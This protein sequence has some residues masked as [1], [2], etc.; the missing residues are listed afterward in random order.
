MNK[1]LEEQLGFLHDYARKQVSGGFLG[2]AVDEYY[3]NVLQS[4]TPPTAEELIKA[5]NNEFEYEYELGNFHETEDENQ[6]IE[7]RNIKTKYPIVIYDLIDKEIIFRGAV[8]TSTKL[9]LLTARFF[10]GVDSN[11]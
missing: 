4:I 11:D 8:R 7:I 2:I 9:N 1:E 3:N 10:M 5:Y 6:K